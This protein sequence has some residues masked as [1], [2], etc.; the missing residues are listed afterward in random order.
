MDRAARSRSSSALDRRATIKMDP[1]TTLAEGCKLLEPHLR[2]HG[3]L[4]EAGWSGKSSGGRSASG[5]FVRKDRKLE[6]HFRWS[7]GLVR[8]HFGGRIISHEELMWAILGPAGGNKYPG[9]SEDPMQGFGDLAEDLKH[10]SKEFLAGTDEE[11]KKRFDYFSTHPRPKGI[12]AIGDADA[13]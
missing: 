3:F 2:P 12:K 5:C 8:Y 7:L 11:L 10:H 9:F 1:T 13:V 6:L 4:F